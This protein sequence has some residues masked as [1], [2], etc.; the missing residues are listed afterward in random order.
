[1]YARIFI[2]TCNKRISTRG[3]NVNHFNRKEILEGCSWKWDKSFYWI[4]NS[5]KNDNGEDY[6][7]R[8]RITPSRVWWKV[9]C[10]R[11]RKSICFLFGGEK[12]G[13][14]DARE[15]SANWI[16]WGK[17]AIVEGCIAL[18]ANGT[19]LYQTNATCPHRQ[20]HFRENRTRICPG[21]WK[22]PRW[23]PPRDRTLSRR[24]SQLTFVSRRATQH[25]RDRVLAP[26]RM[27]LQSSQTK[28]PHS[29][30]IAN[31]DRAR[32]FRDISSSRCSAHAGAVATSAIL[33][34]RK[35]ITRWVHRPMRSAITTRSQLYH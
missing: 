18:V 14:V 31:D 23:N 33:I 9:F 20:P 13:K 22:S 2:S 30:A 29:K 35:S 28:P 4:K 8:S 26:D 1:M 24:R 17:V 15:S 27:S 5:E 16:G 11:E 10:A 21:R 6:E 7:R 12:K 3:A 32:W 34:I 25:C 19:S